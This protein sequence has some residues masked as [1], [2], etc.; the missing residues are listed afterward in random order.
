MAEGTED[1]KAAVACFEKAGL[2]AEMYRCGNTKVVI[3]TGVFRVSDE[4]VISYF[5]SSV[6]YT[7]PN[8]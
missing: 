3:E 2:D 6:F 8:P 5:E 4:H 7:L 1:K